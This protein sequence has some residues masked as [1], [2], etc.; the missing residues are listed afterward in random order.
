MDGGYLDLSGNFL[1]DFSPLSVLSDISVLDVSR[2][3]TKKL[4]SY[5]GL[6]VTK[7]ISD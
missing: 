6:S 4:K 7:I 3:K 1:S 5:S 2:N